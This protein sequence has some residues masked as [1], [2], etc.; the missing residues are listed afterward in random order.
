MRMGLDLGQSPQSFLV[1]LKI[2]LRVGIRIVAAADQ[3]HAPSFLRN[4][5]FGTAQEP[6]DEPIGQADVVHDLDDGNFVDHEI[7][8]R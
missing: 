3:T 4:A 5:C 2:A 6:R 8:S 1:D 7:A